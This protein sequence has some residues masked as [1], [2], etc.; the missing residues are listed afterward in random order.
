MIINQIHKQY[1]YRKTQN[2][3]TSKR[4]LGHICRMRGALPLP[5][6]IVMRLGTDD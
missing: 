1:A 4:T 6:L 2:R 5:V 3:G